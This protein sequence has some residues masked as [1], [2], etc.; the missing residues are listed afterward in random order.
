[1]ILFKKKN[2]FPILQKFYFIFSKSIFTVIFLFNC[3]F[4]NQGLT[5]PFLHLFKIE[6]II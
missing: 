6:N 4:H 5:F 1:M 2:T 3:K